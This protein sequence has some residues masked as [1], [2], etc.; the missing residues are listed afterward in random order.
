MN[1]YKED[2][3]PGTH[4]YCEIVVN[5]ARRLVAANQDFPGMSSHKWTIWIVRNKDKNAF[6]L[7]V[8][9]IQ[10][11]HNVQSPVFHLVS[12]A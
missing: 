2:M 10:G 3:L 12:L 4:P 7:P 11:K 1:K 6:V 8:S 5:I 9:K